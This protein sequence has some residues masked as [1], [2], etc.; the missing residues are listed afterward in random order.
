MFFLSTHFSEDIYNSTIQ[1]TN[2]FCQKPFSKL[3]S[4]NNKYNTNNTQEKLV[5]LMLLVS[6]NV[7]LQ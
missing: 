7:V 6:K 2:L 3:W 5:A 4:I 1:S